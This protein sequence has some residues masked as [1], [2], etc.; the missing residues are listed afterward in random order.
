ML[1]NDRVLHEFE[2][3]GSS[4]I[5]QSQNQTPT[6]SLFHSLSIYHP[7]DPHLPA[8]PPLEFVHKLKLLALVS[9]LFFKTPSTPRA[10]P[11]QQH[12]S[13]S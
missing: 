6:T 7:W 2:L 9:P 10:S 8:E 11:Q 5:S 1:I 12:Y 4:F 13:F 3:R